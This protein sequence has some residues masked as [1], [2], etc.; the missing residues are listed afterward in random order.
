VIVDSR[1]K[2]NARLKVDSHSFQRDHICCSGQTFGKGNA[3]KGTVTVTK[4][5][6]NGKYNP[7][8]TIEQEKQKLKV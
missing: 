6:T 2:L 4:Q 8:Q 1:F 3:S 7:I 5:R